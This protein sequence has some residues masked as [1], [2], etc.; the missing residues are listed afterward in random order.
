MLG[1]NFGSAGFNQLGVVRHFYYADA[2]GSVN[3]HSFIEAESRNENVIF[4]SDGQDGL[5]WQSETF[6]SVYHYSDFVHCFSP[7]T[8]NT[9]LNLHDSSHLP[10]LM[11]AVWSMTC[12]SLT[13]PAIAVYRAFSGAKGTAG[14]CI[15]NGESQQRFAGTSCT[16]V[17][18]N[19]VYILVVKVFDGGQYRVGRCL[20]QSAHGAVFDFECQLSQQFH[21]AF[22]AF[23]GCDP[24]KNFKHS[25]GA[26]SAVG[27]FSAGF[28]GCEV[29]E[30]SSHIHHTGIFIHDNHTAGSDDGSGFVDFFIVYQGVNQFHGD[31]SAGRSTHLDGLEF[32]VVLDAA[33]DVKYDLL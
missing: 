27:A 19:M 7:Y 29:K 2:T 5:F 1:C 25:L 8:L 23:S 22:F 11:Q 16:F 12:F 33:T 21:V 18:I 15:G 26:D 13:F 4:L 14:T 17:V 24:L 20:S 10:H 31:T 30:V 28:L 3:G 9:A 6:L 32:F